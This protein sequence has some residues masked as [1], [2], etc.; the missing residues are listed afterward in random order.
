[1]RTK[2]CLVVLAAL[3]L[4]SVSAEAMVCMWC[5]CTLD[6]T[7]SCRDENTWQPSTCGAY[8]GLCAQ[9]PECLY[10]AAESPL[11]QELGSPENAP[12]CSDQPEP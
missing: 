2:L 1:M 8:G 11:M 4:G 9:N 3:V 5:D 7:K 12:I 10:R 6:C